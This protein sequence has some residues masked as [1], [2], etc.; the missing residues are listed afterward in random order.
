M[1]LRKLEGRL[2]KYNRSSDALALSIV[3]WLKSILGGEPDCL[4]KSDRALADALSANPVCPQLLLMSIF[5]DIVSDNFNSAAKKLDQALK[6][7]SYFKLTNPLYYGIVVYLEAL[8]QMRRDGGL[9]S[10]KRSRKQLSA[11]KNEHPAL[12]LVSAM[13][14]MEMGDRK[15][16]YADLAESYKRGCASPF[17]Y[18]AL[19][20]LYRDGADPQDPL[21]Y[22]FLVWALEHDAD[23]R[24]ISRFTDCIRT[25]FFANESAAKLLSQK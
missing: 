14:L 16:A 9:R 21:A 6:Y 2:Q 5:V 12:L 18:A 13:Y 19:W 10:E 20:E 3:Y 7:R 4:E 22:P 11:I 15:G 25:D 8:L 24:P 1:N 23:L 17:L